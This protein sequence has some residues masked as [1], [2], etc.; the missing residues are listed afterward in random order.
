MT[1]MTPDSYLAALP[2]D[3][4]QALSDLRERLRGL[5]PE[6]SE[7]ISYAM[8]GFRLGKKMVAGYAGF[9]K[10]CGFYP[11]SGTVVP[12]LAAEFDAQGFMHSKS[13]VLFTPDR[14]L[15]DDLLARLIDLR[16]AELNG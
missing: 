9:A 4:R 14:P 3:Q 15:P 6:A 5:L 13:G 12:Q 7:V 16:R 1:A 10:H 8:P 11:H 2:E